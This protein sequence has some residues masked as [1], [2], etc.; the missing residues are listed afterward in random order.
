MGK[1]RNCSFLN[2]LRAFVGK[3]QSQ[4]E[5]INLQDLP[6]LFFHLTTVSS[7]GTRKLTLHASRESLLVFSKTF[8]S[9]RRSQV[10]LVKLPKVITFEL[11]SFGSE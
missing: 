5:V 3:R 4:M 2:P 7:V 1:Y 11:V 8:N 6:H 10:K 9:I